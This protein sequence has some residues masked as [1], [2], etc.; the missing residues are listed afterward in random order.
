MSQ[1]SRNDKYVEMHRYDL[2]ARLLKKNHR[3]FNVLKGS[4]H[5]PLSLSSPYLYYE[6]LLDHI[7]RPNLKVLEIGS[8]TGTHT[9]FP[10]SKGSKVL[11]SDISSES[12]NFLKDRF[13]NF[14]KLT[15]KVIDMEK[16]NFS[17]NSFDVVISAGA[18]SYG[19]NL[20]VA[21]EIYRVLKF[22]GYFICV[23]SLN[24]NPIYR[25]NRWIHY[26]KG[27]RSLST[28]LH[29]PD[30]S[31]ILTYE[32]IFKTV[33]VRYFGAASFLR[34]LLKLFFTEKMIKFFIDRIDSFFRVH[35]SAFK[36]VMIARKHEYKQRTTF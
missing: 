19:D 22:N 17:K 2:K 34:P 12:L 25:L 5:I 23:D 15:V 9:Y 14:K 7:L 21:K 35:K 6:S 31:T 11:A 3:K 16:I 24:H 30:C 4:K 10:L 20:T 1:S 18:L 29:M 8:G 32:K 28:L 26:Q 27:Q 36:F 13:K 33:K